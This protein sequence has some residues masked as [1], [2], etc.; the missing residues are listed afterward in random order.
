MYVH[1]IYQTKLMSLIKVFTFNNLIA[2]INH[3]F[4]FVSPS[5]IFSFEKKMFQVCNL[6]GDTENIEVLDIKYNA[7]LHNQCKNNK[8]TD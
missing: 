2:V 7:T 5:P 3:W 1:I 4:K 8:K 6:I